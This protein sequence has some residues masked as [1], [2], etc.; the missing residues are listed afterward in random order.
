VKVGVIMVNYKN[1]KELRLNIR[2][3]DYQEQTVGLC[4]GFVQTNLVILPSKYAID[5]AA[6]CVRNPKPCP[7]LDISS[8]GKYD[9]Y[10][11][12]GADIRTDLPKY[13]IYRNGKLESVCNEVKSI[14]SDDYVCFLLGCSHTFESFLL[15]AN[16][17]LRYQEQN[18]H[19][20]LYNTN[21][22][23]FPVGPFKGTVIVSMRPIPKEK[24][25]QATVISAR[26]PRVHGGPL[27]IGNPSLIGV[28]LDDLYVGDRVNFLPGDIPVFWACGVTPQN[29]AL[30][31]K[32][33][34]MIT[35][36]PG[37][38]FVTDFLAED[39]G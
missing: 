14:W 18:I 19:L 38:M 2:K 6:F 23:L 25:A 7:L 37:H 36:A 3:G 4:P 39:I 30:E 21:I 32:I 26:Y 11:A 1:P 28:E 9:T 34:Y 12:E 13:H 8:P 24:V 27:H 17:P 33:P 15:S 22:E 5:F 20:S 31:V 35:H 29:I 16:I 10:L